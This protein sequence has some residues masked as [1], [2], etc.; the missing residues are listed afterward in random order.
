M[1]NTNNDKQ[2]FNFEVK[3]YNGISIIEETNT[4]Y[5]NASRMCTD[6]NKTWRKYKQS[7]QWKD[8]IEAFNLVIKPKVSD[9]V[10]NLP[11]S[12][13]AKN[14]VKPEFQGEYIHPK[15]VHFVAEYC[16]KIYAFKVAE[17]MDSINNS[18]HEQLK[19]ENKEDTP[20]NAK[21]VFE[22]KVEQ[23]IEQRDQSM[24]NALTYGY[25]DSPYKLDS[26][27]QKDLERDINAYMNAKEAL[28]KARI[29]LETSKEAVETWSGFVHQYFPKFEF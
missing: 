14:G 23:I 18:V 28:D 2:N 27:E 1:T 24:D 29:M 19:Q 25:R 3:T 17:L 5:V 10:Q 4:K 12:F 15:L 16:S 8:T 20:E 6:N 22:Q 9:G 13:E 26:W 21:P 7:K 11:T